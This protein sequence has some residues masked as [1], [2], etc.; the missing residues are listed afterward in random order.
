[1]LTFGGDHFISYPLLKAY[2]KKYGPISLLQVAAHCDTQEDDG[3]RLDHG[4]M[5]TRAIKEGLIDV[6]SST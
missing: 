6:N 4:T 1:M 5:F 2:A 3:V